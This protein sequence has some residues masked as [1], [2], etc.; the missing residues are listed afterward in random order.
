MG[1]PG[2]RLASEDHRC[3]WPEPLCAKSHLLT[4]LWTNTGFQERF[5]MAKDSE[6]IEQQRGLAYGQVRNVGQSIW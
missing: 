4:M 2:S 6:E 1:G 5:D 3:R